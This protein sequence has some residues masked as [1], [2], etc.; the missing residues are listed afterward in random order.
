MSNFG[1]VALALYLR[2]YV[3]NSLCVPVHPEKHEIK[4]VNNKANMQNFCWPV[5]DHEQTI[6]S[7]PTNPSGAG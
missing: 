2:D 6:K 3:K 5:I 1:A 4:T 7:N